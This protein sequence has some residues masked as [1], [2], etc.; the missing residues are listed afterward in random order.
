M[1]LAC[2]SAGS[3][4]TLLSGGGARRASPKPPDVD[5][6]RNRSAPDDSRA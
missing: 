5:R 1:T 2:G 4:A 3:E 6:D